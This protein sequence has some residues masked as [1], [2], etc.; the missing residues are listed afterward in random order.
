MALTRVNDCRFVNDKE[1][2]QRSARE[3]LKIIMANKEKLLSVRNGQR[4]LLAAI[5]FSE[6]KEEFTPNQLA[7]IEN[8][9]EKIWKG[10]G[11]ESVDRHIDKKK[12]GLRYGPTN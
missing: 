7:Y 9:Y 8:I 5:Q 4:H 6:T 11:F 10:A 1:Q 3:Q 2:A 12:K